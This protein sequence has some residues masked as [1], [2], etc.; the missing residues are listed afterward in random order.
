VYDTTTFEV[1]Y[2]TSG[3][4]TFVIDH[5]F[6]PDKYLVHACLEGPEA[7]VYYR[8]KGIIQER[9]IEITLPSYVKHIATDFSVQITAVNSNNIFYTSEVD[10]E[11]GAFKVFG[12]PGIFFWHVY[13]KRQ[14]IEVEP[15]KSEVNVKGTGP[16]KWL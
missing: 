9:E 10:E 15:L 16:Y 14:T 1:S 7:G 4:K 13:G 11:T 8:G 6:S 2:A 12:K 3:T 5:P